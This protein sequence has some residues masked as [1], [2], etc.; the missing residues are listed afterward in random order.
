MPVKLTVE[1]MREKNRQ[2]NKK[3]LAYKR[4]LRKFQHRELAIFQLTDIFK[5]LKLNGEPGFINAEAARKRHKYFKLVNPCG[6]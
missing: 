2:F 1:E 4:A 3:L 5:R 6:L